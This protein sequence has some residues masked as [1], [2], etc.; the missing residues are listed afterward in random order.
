MASSAVLTKTEPTTAR[1]TTPSLE[2]PSYFNRCL[3]TTTRWIWLVPRRSGVLAKRSTPSMK[4]LFVGR[5]VHLV[6][7]DR[8][9]SSD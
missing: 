1:I 7:P 9:D 6:R 4:P 8:R 3:A 5:F 2:A